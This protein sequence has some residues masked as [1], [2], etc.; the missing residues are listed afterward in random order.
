MQNAYLIYRGR[1]VL[2]DAVTGEYTQLEMPSGDVR[3]KATDLTAGLAAVEVGDDFVAPE[4]TRF[5][6]MREYFADRDDEAATPVARM[7]GLLNWRMSTKY[8]CNCGTELEEDAVET[9]LKCPKC[10]RIH[11]PRVEPCVITIVEKDDQ[12]LLLRHTQ[13]NQD[14]WCCLAGFIEVGESLEHGL[15]REILEE[16]GLEVENIRYMG[17]QSWPFPDQLMVA[18]YATYK[19]GE[20]KVQ[21]NEILE[22]RWFPKDSIPVSPQPGSI[23]WKLIHYAF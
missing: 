11:Y 3:G 23:S 9:A 16:T 22:A 12:I 19:S 14:L 10:G 20:L 18:F 15:K 1:D 13:R 4:G 2:V 21:E 5:L 8:C 17:S 7:K 6:L